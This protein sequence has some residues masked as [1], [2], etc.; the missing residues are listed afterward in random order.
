MGA[1]TEG[2]GRW[3]LGEEGRRGGGTGTGMEGARSEV[4]DW[5]RTEGRRGGGTGTGMEGAGRGQIGVGGRASG[6]VGDG[7]RRS[8][9][10][11]G[12]MV[13]AGFLDV[14]LKRMARG[15]PTKM[16]KLPKHALA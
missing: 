13:G 12:C 4:A 5:G 10:G 14:K 16:P 3:L 9:G 2:A 6:R 8:D 15:I 7:G 1:G 11:G